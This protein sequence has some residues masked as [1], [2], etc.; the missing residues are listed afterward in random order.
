MFFYFSFIILINIIISDP[1]CSEGI[2]FCSKCN[3]ITNLCVKCEKDIFV[4]DSNGGCQNSQ[5]CI[6]GQNYCIEC[7]ENEKICNQCDIGYYPDENGGCSMIPN[8][9]ISYKGE[10]LQC[11]ENYIIITDGNFNLCKSLSSD[12]YQHCKKINETTSL[13]D[14]CEEDYFLNS[15]DHKCSKVGNCSES[16]LGE[17]KK[18]D[19][20]YYLNVNEKKCI[21]QDYDTFKNC[22]IS[23]NGTKCDVCN[24]ESYITY[25]NKCIHTNYCAHGNAYHCDECIEGYYVTTFA[26]ICTNE[27]NCYNGRK[28]IGICIEC[29]EN[30]YIDLND[31]KCKSNQENNNLLH[32][33]KVNNG[34]CDEC[35]TGKY[36][37]K[38]KKCINTPHCELSENGI[39]TKCLDNYY[40]GLDNKCTNIEHCI[41][42][43]EFFNCIDCEEKYYYNKDNNTCI[44]G[45]EINN[46]CKYFSTNLCVECKEGFYLNLDDHLCY[47]NEAKDDFFKCKKSYMGKCIE[48]LNGYYL[49]FA[50]YKCS[51]ARYCNIIENEK[52]CLVCSYSYCLDKKSGYCKDNTIV[53]DIDKKFYFRCNRTNEEG[54][55]CEICL[56][57]YELKD[58]LCFDETHCSEKDEEG[59]CKKCQKKEG[60]FY[61]QCLSKVFG[62]IEAFSDEY[63]LECNNLSNIGECT[64]CLDEYEL[65]AD[66][67]CIEIE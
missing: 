15:I 16:F 21:M 32:C 6:L 66:N 56:E 36:L 13:C 31:G 59:N 33:K 4:P 5:K 29:N 35:I 19:I 28:D 54:N 63:C 1:N 39:C 61:E 45:E 67:I 23:Y 50:D 24:D 44:Y 65:D 9:Q 40:L 3:P 7:S 43:D 53:N 58:G 27:K 20:G 51:K 37:S 52:R 25:D 30:Y 14:E 34:E 47:S 22:K 62:C 38:D 60:E 46:N 49:G 57:E 18:C 64:K 26:G 8:C 2:N 42:S 10:C 41:Y 11:K 55:A 12:D 48:C 17:C